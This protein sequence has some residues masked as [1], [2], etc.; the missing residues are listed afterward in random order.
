MNLMS[1]WQRLKQLKMGYNRKRA[2]RT[3]NYERKSDNHELTQTEIQARVDKMVDGIVLAD[4]S[5]AG[6]F[7]M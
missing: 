2:Q 4:I 3:L 6:M 1:A 5:S 7:I